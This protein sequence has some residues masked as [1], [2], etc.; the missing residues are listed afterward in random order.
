[1]PA[2]QVRGTCEHTCGFPQLQGKQFGG[3]Q[4]AMPA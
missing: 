1:V 4:A 3:G 2:A